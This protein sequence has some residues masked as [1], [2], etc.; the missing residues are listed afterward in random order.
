MH[1]ETEV[2]LSSKKKFWDTELISASSSLS[3]AFQIVFGN[4]PLFSLFVLFKS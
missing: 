3:F 2:F 4:L 1:L